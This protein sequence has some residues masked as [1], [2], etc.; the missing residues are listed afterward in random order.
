MK[1]FSGSEMVIDIN[2]FD[3]NWQKVS[4]Q[5][6]AMQKSFFN[7]HDFAIT[8]NYYIFFQNDMSFQMVGA[9][10]L[11]SPSCCPLP[12]VTMCACCCCLC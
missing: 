3:E 10:Q 12:L 6:F 9:P 1:P 2:E 7:P 4:G 5:T 8:D 11:A